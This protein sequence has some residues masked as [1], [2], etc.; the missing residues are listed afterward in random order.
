MRNDRFLS[1]VKYLFSCSFPIICHSNHESISTISQGKT[2]HVYECAPLQNNTNTVHCAITHVA[3]DS[4]LVDV[5]GINR[6][7]F[8]IPI[9]LS[10]DAS[11]SCAQ[12]YEKI[13]MYV[14]SFVEGSSI[15]KE[16]LKSNLRLKFESALIPPDA[17]ETLPAV[18]GNKCLENVI[19]LELEW[20]DIVDS[21]KTRVQ[22]SDF[23]RVGCHP[24]YLEHQKKFSSSDPSSVSLYECFD[25]FTQPGE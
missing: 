25:S 6:Q 1:S 10:F 14:E 15:T 11:F 20:V 16:V 8:G 7:P 3:V 12:I 4:N 18:I 2:A 22:R 19:L 21:S 9:F 17:N 5:G 23:T 24:S 13:S